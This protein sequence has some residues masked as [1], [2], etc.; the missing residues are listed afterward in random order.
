MKYF[1]NKYTNLIKHIWKFVSGIFMCP[2][3]HS[4]VTSLFF[5]YTMYAIIFKT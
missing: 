1:I 5:L 3:L 4:D 2:Y